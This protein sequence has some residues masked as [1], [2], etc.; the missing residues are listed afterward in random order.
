MTDQDFNANI[1]LIK[2]GD[3]TGLKNIYEEYMTYIYSVVFTYVKNREDAEDIC[4]DF[5]IKLYNIAADFKEGHGH[6][7]YMATIARN[8]AIDHI[9][10]HGREELTEDFEAAGIEPNTRSAEDEAVGTISFDE[11]LAMLKPPQPEIVNM[12]LMG[13]LSFKEIAET[14]KLPMGT[15]TWHYREA[16]KKLRRYV[17][18]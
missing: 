17:C 13:Q 5:F 12:K 1:K 9:R 3:K 16:V 11:A 14:L 8:M 7:G 10:K 2:D 18:A 4:N 15:V 6:K